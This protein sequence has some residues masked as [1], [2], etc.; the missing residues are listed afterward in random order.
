VTVDKDEIE[1][2]KEKTYEQLK[3][4]IEVHGFRK[5][6]VPRDIAEKQI[7]SEK[8]YKSIID[9]IYLEVTSKEKTIV[10]SYDFKFFGNLNKVS[11]L[12]IEFIAELKPIVS[13]VSLD[14]I[15]EKI[16]IENVEVSEEDLKNRINF[17]IKQFETIENSTKQI[18]ENFD[19]AI[20]DFEG[21]IENEIKPFKGGTAKGYQIKINEIINGKKHFIDNFEDQLIGMK[22]GDIKEVKVKFPESYHDI[23]LANKNAIFIVKLNFIKN[24]IVPEYNSEFVKSQGFEDLKVYEE[25]LRNNIFETKQYKAIENFKKQVVTEIIKL[26]EIS[27]IPQE[28]INVENQKEMQTYLRRINKTE[29]QFLKE[30][31]GFSKEVFTERSIEVIKTLLVLEEIASQNDIIVLEEEVESYVLKN[32]NLFKNDLDRKEKIKNELMNNKKQYDLMENA[33]KNEKTVK[34]LFDKCK[35]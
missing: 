23:N 26:S 14:I 35:L 28:M 34:F 15:K 12:T 4:K 19:I 22:I 2:R 7:S 8:L 20:I 25:M 1:K 33:V 11:P 30:N 6:S 9:E 3:S 27:P 32:S 29:E 18:L 21:C 5:G 31:K 10:N 24:K 17:E 13:I 16:K